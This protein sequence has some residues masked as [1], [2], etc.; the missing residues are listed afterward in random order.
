MVFGPKKWRSKPSWFPSILVSA[1]QQ[2]LVA[3]TGPTLIVDAEPPAGKPDVHNKHAVAWGIVG[4]LAAA[5]ELVAIQHR[6]IGGD[7]SKANRAIA[8]VALVPLLR[9]SHHDALVGS[10]SPPAQ[11]RATV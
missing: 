11:T 9:I 2:F 10:G 5:G 7:I 4:E 1:N 6:Q 3:L 8:E